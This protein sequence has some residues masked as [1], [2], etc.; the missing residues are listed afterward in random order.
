MEG[1]EPVYVLPE[2]F[3]NDND[4]SKKVTWKKDA[5]GYRL[6]IEAAA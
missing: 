2:P 1:L 3:E 5:N 4:W 6:P